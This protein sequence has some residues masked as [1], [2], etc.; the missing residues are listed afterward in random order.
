MTPASLI[1]IMEQAISTQ[2]CPSCG[3]S[4]NFTYDHLLGWSYECPVCSWACGGS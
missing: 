3:Q 4:L 2:I 1:A